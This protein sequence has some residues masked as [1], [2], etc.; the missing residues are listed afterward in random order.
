MGTNDTTKF[1]STFDAVPACVPAARRELRR[2][3]EQG[4][5]AQE[6][7]PDVLLAVTEACANAARHAY[8]GGEGVV[9][10]Q[11]VDTDGSLS[12]VVRDYGTGIQRARARSVGMGLGLPLMGRLA[13]SLE[14]STNPGSGTEVRMRFAG[15]PRPAR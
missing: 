2:W 13:T 14:I 10:I 12:I 9:R 8:P 3:L 7:I 4:Q 6:C 1:Q 11:A 5:F 15:T